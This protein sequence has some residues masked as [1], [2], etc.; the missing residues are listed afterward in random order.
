MRR[1]LLAGAAALLLGGGLIMW[2]GAEPDGYTAKVLDNIR[3]NCLGTAREKLRAQPELAAGQDPEAMARDY[4]ACVAR[5][6]QERLPYEDFRAIDKAIRDGVAPDPA[7]FLRLTEAIGP[8]N[9]NQG[10][11]K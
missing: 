9:R 2:R 11:P 7:R 4:C 5:S 8:C 10:Q 1:W 3:E 6:V